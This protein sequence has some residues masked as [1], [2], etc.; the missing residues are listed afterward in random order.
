[1]ARYNGGRSFVEYILL[2]AFLSLV[3]V[4]VVKSMGPDVLQVWHRANRQAGGGQVERGF[5]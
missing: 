2:I 5:R 1:V 4:A 3:I